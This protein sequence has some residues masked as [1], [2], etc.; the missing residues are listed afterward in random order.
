MSPSPMDKHSSKPPTAVTPEP[1]TVIE[2]PSL[3]SRSADWL[4]L[5]EGDDVQRAAQLSDMEDG[6]P[7]VI[8]GYDLLAELGRGGMGVV[9]KA[10]QQ[11]LNRLVALKVIL[12]GAHANANDLARFEA[13]ARTLAKLQHPNIVQIFEV[14]RH[15]GRP[16]LTLEYVSGGSLHE[17]VSQHPLKPDAAAKL[18]ATLADAVHYAHQHGIVHR[19]LK[20][21]NVLLSLISQQGSAADTLVQGDTATEQ[22]PQ[23]SD[24]APPPGTASPFV[25]PKITDF[26]LAKH[27][28][29]EEA[30]P[31]HT[32]TGM[33]VG[34]P[35]YMAPEQAASGAAV[36]PLADVYS[37]GAILYECLTGR[38][39]FQAPSPMETLLQV[40]TLDVIPPS[41]LQPMVPRDLE[42]ITLKCLAKEPERRY[43]SA[44]ALAEDLRRFVN[45]QPILARPASTWER[46][47]KWTRRRPAVA[48]L[49]SLLMVVILGALSSLTGLWRVAEGHRLA[50]ELQRD[51]ALRQQRR[52]DQRLEQAFQAVERYLTQ[53]AGN[54][55]LRQS[56]FLTLRRDLLLSAVPFYE[57][58][59]TEKPGDARL[60]LSQAKAYLKLGHLYGDLGEVTKALANYQQAEAIGRRLAA[61]DPDDMDNQ[62]VLARTL[63]NQGNLHKA[64]GQLD[65]AEQRLRE[66]RSLFE[67]MATRP[68][69]DW[70]HRQDWAVTHINLADV[71]ARA[72]KTSEA[73]DLLRKAQP[74]LQTLA[75]LEPNEPEPRRFLAGTHINLGALLADSER[76]VEAKAH[77]ETARSLF[78]ELFSLG[79]V[80][81]E[82]RHECSACLINLGNVCTDL[83]EFK[84][85]EAAYRAAYDLL[86]ALV[87][88]F[89]DLMQMHLFRGGC[90][91]N[92]SNA[93]RR[94]GLLLEA[95]PWLEEAEKS[96]RTVLSREPRHRAARRYFRNVQQE[97][98]EMLD[99]LKRYPEAV[100]AWEVAAEYN[101]EPE[102]RHYYRLMKAVALTQMGEHAQATR[103]TEELLRND[104][105]VDADNLVNAA[106]VFALAACF[107]KEADAPLANR[108]VLR[109]L[110]L[111]RQAQAE[112]HF[113]HPEHVRLLKENESLQSL[114]KHADF[115][116]LMAE[117]DKP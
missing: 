28:E 57:S 36:G 93:R 100:S 42:T 89:P 15:E 87:K 58:F 65:E 44:A 13:E 25:S 71:L 39:P 113:R 88:E 45:H 105:P 81:P 107:V 19:D 96:L 77:Y 61:Q 20:P 52:A 79:N 114:N 76:K 47:A 6:P 31:T 69:A 32:K 11:S 37:L 62:H 70:K 55:R 49:L 98:G 99:A 50:A 46:L 84:E 14:G 92:L 94:S 40:S 103:Q 38:P 97:K 29:V 108:Y 95:L 23:P 48:A 26:G 90:C 82:Y 59:V 2:N 112:G 67:T 24:G 64:I 116:K 54:L 111:L 3:T 7:P 21:A 74:I 56:N 104:G 72:K 53:V 115:Q 106:Q 66:A 85:G 51:E 10:R 27:L 43:A 8:A 101:D 9:Y 18:L 102:Y 117:I 1:A 41:R 78:Q 5:F 12:L 75:K 33:V 16:Y 80:P 63:G 34:T 86:D 109:A 17:L 22:P 4:Q 30:S 110:E 68:G 83:E 60:E 35:C 73:E 91:L